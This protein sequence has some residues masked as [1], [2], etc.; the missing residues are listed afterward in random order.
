MVLCLC[1]DSLTRRAAWNIN[2]IGV[3]FFGFHIPCNRLIIRHLTQ[4][5]HN[6]QQKFICQSDE[7]LFVVDCAIVGLNAA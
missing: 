5:S 2:E 1:C 7:S 3:L 6:Q 4:Q